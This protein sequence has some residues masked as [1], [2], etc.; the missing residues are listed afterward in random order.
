MRKIKVYIDGSCKNNKN[1]EKAIG[2]WGYIFVDEEDNIIK[3]NYGKLRNGNQN[4]QRAEMEAFYMAL[5]SINAFKKGY[6]FD[7]YSD[8]DSLVDSINGFAERKKN[9]DIWNDIEPLCLSL[10]KNIKVHHVTAHADELFNNMA[11]KLAKAGANSLLK[12]PVK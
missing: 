6:K 2:G 10:C 11:D 4:S 3:H 5:L 7:I 12:A 1:K 9:K 8:Y